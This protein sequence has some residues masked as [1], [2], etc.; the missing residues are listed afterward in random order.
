MHNKHQY[1]INGQFDQGLTPLD[2]GFAYGDGVFRTMLVEDG[3]PVAWQA[4]YN[5]LFF[6]CNAL[7]IVCPAQEVLLED[8]ER[9][10]NDDDAVAVCKIV[11]TRGESERGYMLPSV[12]K[13][14]RVVIKTTMPN[15]PISRFERGVSLHLCELRLA[16]Q[17]KLA[18]IKHLNRMENV[19]ARAEWQNPELADGVLLDTHGN[20]IECTAANLFAR[21]GKTLS[22]PDLSYCGVSGVT[23]E[24]ILKLAKELGYQKAETDISIE[25][26]RKADEVIMCNSLYGAWQVVS[27]GDMEWPAL[28]LAEK[29]RK[30]LQEHHALS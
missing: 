28:G 16:H 7:N 15:Y 23:R 12:V 24:L 10:F 20:V 19:L 9:L 6:D 21:Y 26:L 27:I 25:T 11:I 22:T 4:H 18:G 29:V 5:K 17:P 3:L 2:R 1:L 30:A 13:P 8:I 14:S